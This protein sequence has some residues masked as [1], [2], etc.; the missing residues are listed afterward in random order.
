MRGADYLRSRNNYLD[1]LDREGLI[2]YSSGDEEFDREIGRKWHGLRPD[3]N[4]FSHLYG[5]EEISE[6]LKR[7]NDIIESDT[8][9]RERDPIATKAEYALAE[10]L[11]SRG[12]L[13]PESSARITSKFDDIKAGA[14]LLITLPDPEDPDGE[15]IIF[16]VDITTSQDCHILDKKINS[17]FSRLSKNNRTRLKYFRG[18]K[19]PVNRYI[20]GIA[21]AQVDELAGALLGRFASEEIEDLVRL[22]LM[23]E[24]IYQAGKQIEF[25][26]KNY[27][28]IKEGEEKS[29]EEIINFFEDNRAAIQKQIPPEL[30]ESIRASYALI[31]N[32]LEQKEILL[33]NKKGVPRL[34]NRRNPLEEEPVH[35]LTSFRQAA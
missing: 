24:L 32:L 27:D 28:V 19:K 31:V 20:I 3:E 2:D 7:I 17:E 23:E 30:F 22:E 1:R 6:D 9:Q 13:G 14:D 10:G 18:V 21:P 8:Y 15:D 26:L 29:Q 5:Q 11:G 35:Y 16:V 25:I 34:V 33:E 4:K 12:W